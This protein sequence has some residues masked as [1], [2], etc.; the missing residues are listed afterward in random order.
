M[1]LQSCSAA[2]LAA[3]CIMMVRFSTASSSSVLVFRLVFRLIS[4]SIISLNLS[5]FIFPGI[6]V[7]ARDVSNGWS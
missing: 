3:L 1:S 2:L 7:G 5:Q 4:S 6:R